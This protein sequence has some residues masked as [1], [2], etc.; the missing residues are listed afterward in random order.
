VPI[1][2]QRVLIDTPFSRDAEAGPDLVQD[3]VGGRSAAGER[4]PCLVE[5]VA[6]WVLHPE[7]DR[8]RR[9]PLDCWRFSWPAAE[10]AAG[11][12]QASDHRPA[13]GGAASLAS[14]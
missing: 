11:A 13:A 10:A 7:S 5:C 3:A 14:L 4:L 8:R 6:D 9:P 2:L 12:L 1:E